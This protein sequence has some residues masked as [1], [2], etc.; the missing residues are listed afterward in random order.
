MEESVLLKKY[1][2]AEIYEIL[3]IFEEC[4][5]PEAAILKRK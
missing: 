5:K 2:E 3:R 4:S 1:I